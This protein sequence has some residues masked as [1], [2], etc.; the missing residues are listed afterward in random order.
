MVFGL[1]CLAYDRGTLARAREI[2][3]GL[4][5]LSIGGFSIRVLISYLLHNYRYIS[6]ALAAS[7]T[8]FS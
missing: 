4:V 3:F 6:K 8:L 7:K 2:E 1:A 5:F